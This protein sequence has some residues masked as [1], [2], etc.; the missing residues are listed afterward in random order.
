MPGIYQHT[1]INVCSSDS[2]PTYYFVNIQNC[3]ISC[4]GYNRAQLLTDQGGVLT[5][6][7]PGSEPSSLIKGRSIIEVS[8]LPIIL[9]VFRI[10]LLVA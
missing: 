10:K 6:I 8:H 9:S 7:Y 4:P 1:Q 5:F 3:F 2:S